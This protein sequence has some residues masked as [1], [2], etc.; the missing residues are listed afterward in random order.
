MRLKSMI[1]LVLI[2][3]TL[4]SCTPKVEFIQPDLVILQEYRTESIGSID[5]EVRRVK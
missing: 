1:V 3:L 4:N 2:V 5:Y